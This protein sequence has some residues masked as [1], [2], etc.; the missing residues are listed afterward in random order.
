MTANKGDLMVFLAGCLWGSTGIFVNI[1]NPYGLGSTE[2]SLIKSLGGGII[3]LIGLLIFGRDLIK[4]K[5]KDAWIFA[6]VGLIS[7][8]LH[9]ISYMK[10]I[11]LTSMAAAAVLLYTSP[12]FVSLMFFFCYKEKFTARKVMALAI[13]FAG[14]FLVSGIL[15]GGTKLTTMGI[16]T[17]IGASAAYASYTLFSRF[18]L[19]RGYK[20]MTI[21]LYA[22][23]LSG[24]GTIPLADFHKFTGAF[25]SGGVKLG[26]TA[27]AFLC[28]SCL[29]PY[30]LYTYG[31]ERTKAW[32]AAIISSSELIAAAVYGLIFLSQG[33]SVLTFIGILLIVCAVI[34]M[35]MPQKGEKH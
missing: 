13:T 31:L 30:V 12:I 24:I 5:L 35:N 27:L 29:S 6:C 14:C 7:L 15:G 22:F 2:I 9:N 21:I 32:K 23:L 20:P 4:I 17:G 8:L 18:A 34:L 3:L 16:L 11:E 26:L 10:T 25:A 28:I 33:I 19:D 1:F